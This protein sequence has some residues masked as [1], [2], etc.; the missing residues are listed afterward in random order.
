MAVSKFVGVLQSLLFSTLKRRWKPEDGVRTAEDIKLGIEILK[1]AISD[2][3]VWIVA[4]NGRVYKDFLEATGIDGTHVWSLQVCVEV[5]QPS[6]GAHVV[7]LHSGDRTP[8]QREAY[9][10]LVHAMG[11]VEN[12]DLWHIGKWRA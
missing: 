8:A 12:I 11:D 4:D 10:A 9:E 6:K 5:Y 7:I 1:Q 2:R 3:P